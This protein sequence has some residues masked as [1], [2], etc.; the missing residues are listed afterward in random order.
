MAMTVADTDILIDALRGKEPARGRVDQ[1]LKAGRL[2]TTSITSFE[3]LSGARSNA[4][5]EKIQLLLAALTIF[6]LDSE[7]SEAAASIR[8]DLEST[9][10]GIGMADYLIAGICLVQRVPLLTRNR[11]HFQRIPGLV[12]AAPGE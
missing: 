6:P 12:L 8:R 10:K 9:G 5:S 4:Q 7:T 11:R 3:L 1:E 2:A